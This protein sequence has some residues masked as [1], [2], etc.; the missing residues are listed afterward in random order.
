MTS[1]VQKI[2]VIG[3]GVSGL[4]A[5]WALSPYNDVKVFEAEDRLGGHS[6]TV[7]IN[8]EGKNLS[9]DVGFIVC[10]PLNYPNFLN[11][12]DCLGVETQP[13]DM[14][15][16]VSD[17]HGFEW[18]SDPSGIFAQKRNL[19]SPR[20]LMMLK[21]IFRFNA[22]AQTDAEGDTLPGYLTLG[23]YL[24]ELG[25]SDTFRTH[26][27][28]PMG[29]AIWSTPEA[30]M[31]S[32]PAKSFIQFFN[33]HKLLHPDR[34]KWRTVSGGSRSYVEKLRDYLGSSAVC[35][36][37]VRRI[38]RTRNGL[39]VCTD[40]GAEF[41]DQIILA[42]HSHQAHDILGDGFEHQA[43]I[44]APM[45]VTQ[46]TAYLHSDTRLMPKRKAAW[47]S[48]NVIKE[49]HDKVT[50][51]YWMNRLQNLE[52]DQ[53]VL[54]TLNPETPPGASKTMG[55]FEFTHPLFDLAA[56]TAVHAIERVNG[57]D[58]L[59][60]AGAWMGHG[61]HEDGLKSGLRVAV[62]LGAELPWTPVDI[63]PYNI[64][65]YA[66]AEEVSPSVAVSK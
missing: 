40:N 1:S 20:F 14:S 48:W 13:S 54:V 26:Y 27:I 49:G 59:W 33:N 19:L 53:P 23:Q 57:R 17:P 42:T 43:S 24:D 4:S 2:A 10:N 34:P 64:A 25:T 8:V 61:F 47:A 62:S 55:K 52:T 6:H 18:S 50:L 60:F 12:L 39:E 56:Q 30:D 45:G 31:S 63:E 28:Y 15:F 58:G 36:T 38:N 51:S 7:D 3:S 37:P 32:Y 44:L 29:A 35:N 65:D 22:R 21:G 16:S 41:F 66:T 11:F 5:A 9:V 46:N